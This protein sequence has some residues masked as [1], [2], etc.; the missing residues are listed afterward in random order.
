ME[1]I[2]DKPND[3]AAV[4]YQQE[5]VT[6]WDQLARQ[7]QSKSLGGYYHF[8]LSQV[9][10]N[11]IPPGERVIELGC[12]RGDLLASLKPSYGVGVDFSP[13]M[14][15]RGGQAHS[16]LHF[17]HAD[18]HSINMNEQFNFIIMS[19]LLNDVWDVQKVFEQASL[20]A[21]PKS[22]IILNIYSRLWE[23][24]LG[25]ARKLGLA[26]SVLQLN[27][28]TVEDILNLGQ[29]ADFELI[30][31]RQEI[32]WPF[33][34]PLISPFCNKFLVKLWPINQL[35]LTNFIVLRPK[36][37]LTEKNAKPKVSVIVPARN[38]AGNITEIFTRTPEMGI[39]TELVFV[40]GHSR[41]KTYAEIERLIIQNP[42]R[43]TKLI[44]QTG[45]GKGDAVRL[46]F[47][48]A[49]GEILIILDADLT[50]PPEDLIRFYKA[51]ISGK[52]DFI[53]GVRLVYPM[54][55]Q[56]MRFMNFLGNKFFS[57]AFS[58]ILEQPIKDTLCGTKAFWKEDYERIAA[59]RSY[60]GDFDPFGDFDLIFGATRLSLKIVDMPIR[61]RERKYGTTNIN[62]WKHGWLLLKMVVFAAL[63]LKFI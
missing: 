49:N 54:E 28:L 62:R 25:I 35:G 19:D 55:K 57:L 51:L 45:I 11:L 9:Y 21:A 10:Q 6:Y 29:L 60:F 41:D 53:N 30:Y 22:R 39:G 43:S 7:D 48:H 36:P 27:W 50:V 34:T 1:D 63:R 44:R 38:E 40:E 15:W 52:G 4:K 47:S 14:L 42:M 8:R 16:E 32:L 33:G 17:V 3:P 20:L 56:A 59:N 23:V 2:L 13:E 46:G 26:R 5:R 24:P 12:G 18:V 37:R 31:Q 58:W 61:Y